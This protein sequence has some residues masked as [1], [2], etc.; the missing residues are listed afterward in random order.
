MIS[1][2]EIM[3]AITKIELK[4][5]YIIQSRAC[6]DERDPHAQYNGGNS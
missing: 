4:R 2:A 5:K 3:L 1:S 6:D